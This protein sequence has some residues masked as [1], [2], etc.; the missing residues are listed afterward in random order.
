MTP[1]FECENWREILADRYGALRRKS[2]R[3]S[4]RGFAK[5]VALAPSTVSEIFSGK[6]SI[7][8]SAAARM[9]KVIGLTKTETEY[10]IDLIERDTSRSTRDRQ[11]ASARISQRRRTRIIP[12]LPEDRFKF[13]ADW[14]HLAI[15]ELS[16]LADF[17]WDVNFI[18]N[19]LGLFSHEISEALG[20][21]ER[22][23]VLSRAKDDTFVTTLGNFEV[24]DQEP[25]V[26]IQRYHRQVLRLAERAI[27]QQGPPNR[28]LAAL[29]LAVNADQ[30]E[31]LR[32][33]LKEFQ[34]EVM[35]RLSD[36]DGRDKLYMFSSQLFELTRSLRG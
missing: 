1:I 26:A 10:W 18:A 34:H 36:G 35:E 11:G 30:L 14:H 32:A 3:I 16:L 2:P 12:S 22:L 13:M 23:G 15:L 21:M 8:A 33:R 9:A 28:D 4:L 27:A 20:R 31:W 6:S 5:S 17:S 29:N 25:S 24:G 19:K 7:S